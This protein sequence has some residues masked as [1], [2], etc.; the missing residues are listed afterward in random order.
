MAIS[1]APD[2]NWNKIEG[3]LTYPQQNKR[4]DFDIAKIYSRTICQHSYII[5]QM[6]IYK[7]HGRSFFLPYFLHDGQ[8]HYPAGA[9]QAA[10][11]W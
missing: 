11:D 10:H 7:S 1:A 8:L 6:H 3:I 4:S 9:S 2:P 5:N